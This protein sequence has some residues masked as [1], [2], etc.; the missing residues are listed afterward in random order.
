MLLFS[1]S[2]P[3]WPEFSNFVLKL[4]ERFSFEKGQIWFNLA[5]RVIYML[6]IIKSGGMIKESRIWIRVLL[7]W[8]QKILIIFGWNLVILVI[9]HS[10]SWLSAYSPILCLLY[11]SMTQLLT[12]S[13]AH[14]TK[15]SSRPQTNNQSSKMFLS[16][17]VSWVKVVKN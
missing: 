4:W 16:L 11:T 13:V 12:H 3:L 7:V 6:E 15:P 14:S 1:P 8:R 2:L 5:I 9:V 10:A 17:A